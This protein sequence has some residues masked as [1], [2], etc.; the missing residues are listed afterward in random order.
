MIIGQR[1]SRVLIG[2][3]PMVCQPLHHAQEITTI[4]IVF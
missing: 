1:D 2:L 4:K 3:A